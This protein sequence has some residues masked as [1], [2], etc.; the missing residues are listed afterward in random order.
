LG[1]RRTRF[2]FTLIPSVKRGRNFPYMFNAG[3]ITEVNMDFNDRFVS[4]YISRAPLALALERSME[5]HILSQNRCEHPVLD[6]GCGDGI[7]ASV[8]FKDK[9]DVGIDPDTKELE[10]ARS[11]DRY[12]EL[13]GCGAEKIPKPD[14]T[15]QT[16]IANSVLE[17]IPTIKEVLTEARRVLAQEGRMYVTV[18]TEK[19]DHFTFPYQFLS[20]IN[21]NL[22]QR[23][24]R[25]YNR[26]WRHYHCYDAAGW[27]KLFNECGWA[28]VQ[29]REYDPKTTCL[30][31]D[32]L[33]P[34]SLP[35]FLSRKFLNRWFLFPF[36]RQWY[37]P[38]LAAFFGPLIEKH[39]SNTK[40]G[41]L[42]FFE[43]RKS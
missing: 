6:L 30:I 24:G 18:P 33:V 36:I 23:F 19:F 20:G 27:Q 14:G 38:G 3:I 42:I 28:A 8:L 43:L 40:N 29:Q 9:I 39:L 41:G 4:S 10:R 5:C 26:F 2:K 37:S 34:L 16:I 22:A 12:K 13:I 25:F 1:Y 15:F 32:S 11:I 7:F 35:S 17:H 21:P 31:F